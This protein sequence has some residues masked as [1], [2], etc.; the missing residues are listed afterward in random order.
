[1]KLWLQNSRVLVINVECKLVNEGH[2]APIYRG[3]I[4]KQILGAF[5]SG[6]QSWQV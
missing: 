6:E 3:K 4:E 5:G 1:M 2:E